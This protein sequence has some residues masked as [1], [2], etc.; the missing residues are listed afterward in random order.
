MSE[1]TG[2]SLP[3]GEISTPTTFTRCWCVDFP[4]IPAAAPIG[5]STF[6]GARVEPHLRHSREEA[7]DRNEKRARQG[8]ADR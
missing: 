5:S 3:G 7:V 8:L 4:A 6:A 1:F 2:D